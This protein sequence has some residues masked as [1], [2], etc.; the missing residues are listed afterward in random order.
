MASIIWTPGT[1]IN[2]AVVDSLMS[3]APNPGDSERYYQCADRMLAVITGGGGGDYY[4]V[5]RTSL[6]KQNVHI[7]RSNG[8]TNASE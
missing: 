5:R 6:L 2:P 1:L 3:S 8:G 4:T 7:F